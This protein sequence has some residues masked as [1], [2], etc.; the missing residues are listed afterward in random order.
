MSDVVPLPVKRPADDS[1]ERYERLTRHLRAE[2]WNF[3]SMP[4]ASQ[5]LREAQAEKR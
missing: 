2:G 4:P 3:P 5:K 1:V